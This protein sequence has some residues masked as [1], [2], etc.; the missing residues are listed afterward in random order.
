TDFLPSKEEVELRKYEITVSLSGSSNENSHLVFGKRTHS[1]LYFPPKGCSVLGRV[2][3]GRHLLDTLKIGDKIIKITPILEK[4]L[5]PRSLMRVQRD[6]KL[7]EGDEIFTKMEIVLDPQSPVCVEHVYNTLSEGFAVE[8]KTSRFIAHDKIKLISIK[9]EGV[10]V[11]ERGVISVRSSGNNAGSV[12]IY[13]QK[14]GISKDHTIVGHVVRGIELADVALRGDLIDIVLNPD[15]LDLLGKRQWE[16]TEVLDRHGIKHIRE[17]FVGDDGI[18][19]EQ[20]PATTLEIYKEGQVKCVGLPEDQILRVRLDEKVAP[21]SVRYF[22][23]VTGLDLRRVGR[24][25]VFFSTKDVILFKGDASLGR[26]VMP[27]NTPKGKV[28]SGEIGVTN[29]VKKFAGMI[30]I[31]L[32]ES[33]KFGPTAESFDGTNLVGIVLENIGVLTD[34]REG[35]RVYIMEGG[36]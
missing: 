8:R 19:V 35:K 24:L 9:S 26:S 2:V 4:K 11:R 1:A 36:K 3:Y 31:R 18:V 14:A 10:G 5:D 27:E 12:Y 21:N 30:G 7:S 16:V 23:R 13:L 32:T 34:L 25:D 33:D 22:R 17:G 15:R 20:Y 6:Y 28:S 29:S